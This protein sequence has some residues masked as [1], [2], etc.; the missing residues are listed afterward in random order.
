MHALGSPL[1]ASRTAPKATGPAAAQQRRPARPAVAAASFPVQQPQQQGARQLQLSSS[2]PAADAVSSGP[3]CPWPRPAAQRRGL[4]GLLCGSGLQHEV[5]SH[6]G[7]SP[8]CTG[9]CQIFRLAC[10]PLRCT[11]PP[12]PRPPANP[13]VRPSSQAPTPP[14]RRC[15]CRRHSRTRRCSCRPRWSAW[16]GSRTTP[17]RWARRRRS[18]AWPRCG[19]TRGSEHAAALRA[20]A[21]LPPSLPLFPPSL[22]VPQAYERPPRLEKRASAPPAWP[23]MYLPRPTN[24]PAYESL[25]APF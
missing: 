9:G 17:R 4:F 16:L 24:Q 11:A 2:G 13:P 5:R 25:S 10:A 8:A 23:R 22:L 19:G 3:T 7:V 14:C 18:P 15:S 6:G 12:P 20:A 1:V 21:P